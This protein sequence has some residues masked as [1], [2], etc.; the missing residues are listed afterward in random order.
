MTGRRAS[1]TLAGAAA[2]LGLSLSGC[3]FT[4]LY[5][6]QGVSPGLSAIEVH[7]PHGRTAYLVGEDLDQAFARDRSAAPVYRLDFT[8]AER[9]YP[10]GLRID[11]VATLY[12]THVTV[13][14]QLIEVATGRLVKAGTEPVQV[15]YDVADQPYAGVAAQQNSQERAAQEAAQRIRIDLAIYF[16]RLAQKK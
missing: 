8:V 15:V 2:A 13:S 11:N 14:Y 7:A 3:G 6:V 4:P 12:E 10:R 9:R 5:A 16:T 1:W